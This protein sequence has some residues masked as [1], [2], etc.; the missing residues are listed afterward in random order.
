MA[1]AAILR[2]RKT[3]IFPQRMRI[4]PWTLSANKISRIR[5]FKMAATA[6]LRNRKTAIWPRW[7]D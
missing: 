2:I 3:T 4:G 7:M 1:A 6:I 5:K